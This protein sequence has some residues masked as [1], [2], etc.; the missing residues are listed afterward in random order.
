M[1]KLW[2]LFLIGILFLSGCQKK[3]KEKENLE[4]KKEEEVIERIPEYKD[5]NQ[6]PISF[7]KLNGS[8][9]NKVTNISGSFHHLEDV[10]FLQ[11]YPSL[12]EVIS[13]K[14][15][16][17][18]SFYHTWQNYNTSKSLKIG[19]SLELETTEKETIFYNILNPSQTMDHWQY[20]MAYLY[21]DYRNRGKNYYSH[22][23]QNEYTD[24]SLFTAFKL[25]CGECDKISSVVKLSVFTY[26]SEVDFLEGVYRGNSQ[27]TISICI[28][29][30][31]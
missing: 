6:T 26:D 10:L 1:K 15:S 22:L 11:I 27:S 7:Y 17:A 30:D 18:N 13:L 2:I 5:E 23:E 28:H 16:F 20:F 9:L 21:D 14:D 25:Q 8:T 4:E 24:T 31:C 19:F 3:E 29:G 12:E